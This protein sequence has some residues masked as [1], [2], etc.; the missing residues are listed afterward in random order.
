MSVITMN[1]A[2]NVRKRALALL[3]AP[4]LADGLAGCETMSQAQQ[5]EIIGGVVGGVLGSQIGDGRGETVAIII[6]SIA[7]SVIGRQIGQNMDDTD[8]LQTASALN[9][10]RTG[11]ATQWINPD[12]GRTYT[13][14][15]TRTFEQNSGPCREFRLDASLGDNSPEEIYGTACLQADGSWLIV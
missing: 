14:T 7:G 8:R 10:S 15:P 12:N 11:Q 1:K 6:G 3:A 5:G 13:V 4:I 9:T 2:S